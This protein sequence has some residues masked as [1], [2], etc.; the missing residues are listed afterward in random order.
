MQEVA[1]AATDDARNVQ[2]VGEDEIAY[3]LNGV[4][5]TV[6]PTGSSDRTLGA[7]RLDLDP[8]NDE[9]YLVSP[10]GHTVAAVV[11]RDLSITDVVTGHT[12][13]ITSTIDDRRWRPYTWSTD[14]ELLFYA[15]QSSDGLPEIR[16][17]D[18]QTSTTRVLAKS[19]TRGA[20]ANLAVPANESVI[21]YALY[22]LGTGS[23]QD[24][25]YVSQNLVTGASS[26]LFTHGL[27]MRLSRDG[28]HLDFV[29]T[30][31]TQDSIGSW[32]ASLAY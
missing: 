20:F 1:V 29:R 14:G 17:Y 21:V 30:I 10:D 11:G 32:E 2:Y 12:T 4:L 5:H 26:V 24:S 3:T 9:P 25:T 31:G 27:G 22:P 28:R 8:T 19:A 13:P 15:D 7:V 23:E 6:S 16:A 18:P